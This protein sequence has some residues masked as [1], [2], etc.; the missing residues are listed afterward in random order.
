[1]SSKKQTREFSPLKALLSVVTFGIVIFIIISNWDDIMVALD[2]IGETNLLI[3]LLLI[4][5]QLMMLYCGGKI[6]FSYHDEKRPLS[7]P[8]FLPSPF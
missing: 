4:P 8:D 5:E 1:M 3:L 6:F 7:A 2:H